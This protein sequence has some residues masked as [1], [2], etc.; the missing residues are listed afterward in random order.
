MVHDLIDVPRVAAEE[1]QRAR[2]NPHGRSARALTHDGRL[3]HTLLAIL[4]GESLGEHAKPESATLQVLSGS[5][6]VSSGEMETRLEAGQLAVL[7]GPS[8]DVTAV[9]DAVAILTTL[10]G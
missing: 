1:L 5:L 6:V 3:R 9:G 7:P 2:A 8:H 10:A 4:D